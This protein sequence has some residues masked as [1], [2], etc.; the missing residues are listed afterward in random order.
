MVAIWIVIQA[1]APAQD[2]ILKMAERMT[3][4]PTMVE[5]K[6]I[7]KRRKSEISDRV[8]FVFSLIRSSYSFQLDFLEENKSSEFLE[9]HWALLRFPADLRLQELQ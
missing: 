9:F 6:S 3:A 7:S 2:G 8:R 4:P 1:A 5:K